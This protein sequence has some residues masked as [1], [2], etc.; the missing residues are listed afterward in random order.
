MLGLQLLVQDTSVI[1]QLNLLDQL[2]CVLYQQISNYL[3]TEN[4]K[5]V[6]L[7]KIMYS[8]LW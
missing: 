1:F 4:K 5:K 3:V 8:L 7:H 6:E 2:T